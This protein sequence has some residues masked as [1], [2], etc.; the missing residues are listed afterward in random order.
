M[1][2]ITDTSRAASFGP[3]MPISALHGDLMDFQKV[4]TMQ[5]TVHESQFPFELARAIS[6]EQF[7]PTEKAPDGTQQRESEPE[8]SND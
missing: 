7:R 2:P 6:A 1:P 8:H 5:R 3:S 4:A